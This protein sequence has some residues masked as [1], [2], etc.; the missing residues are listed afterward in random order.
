MKGDPWIPAVEGSTVCD[1]SDVDQQTS[2][3]TFN[4]FDIKNLKGLGYNMIRLGVVW[5]GAQPDGPFTE[6]SSTLLERLDAVLDLAEEH[7]LQVLID[8][9]QDAVGTAVCG[10]GVPMW[11]SQLAIPNQIG[12]PLWP[13]PK[14]DDGTCGR[15]DTETWAEYAGDNDYNIKNLCCRKLNGGN[16]GQLT[17]T[18]QAQ[19]TMLYLF[20]K[21]RDVF[22]DFVGKIAQAVNDKPA[23][24]G[25]E[26]MNEPP[27]IERNLMY[28][29]WQTAAE[30]VRVFSS[31][32]AVGVA[33]TANGALPI[34]DLD[35]REET[36]EWLTDGDQYLFYAFHWYGTPKTP[37]Q[38]ID[39]A[40]SLGEKWGM[41]VHLTEFGGYGGDSYG[42]ATQRAAKA[43]GVG[44][45]YWHYSDYC[46][47]KHCPDGSPD[48]Y[49]PL[50]DGDR[51]GACI[52]G[53]GS[54]NHSFAC[55]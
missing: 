23:A 11:F 14:L 4:E 42:C 44:S 6:L 40:V 29:T 55:P 43:A 51:W 2:C 47:P 35:L 36:V 54:G 31:D 9:H 25:I 27:A 34:G 15:N 3:A 12:K 37:D 22:A 20:T 18:S 46:W 16:W 19:E 28:K 8:L 50:P 52:T 41:P 39:N 53:W 1:T 30:A 26:L 38:A 21:G 48:G 24:F 7:D 33:D 13:L 5:A 17:S 32:I 49:C 10:E 45:S